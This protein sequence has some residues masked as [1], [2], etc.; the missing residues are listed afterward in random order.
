[1]LRATHMAQP[2]HVNTWIVAG[3]FFFPYLFKFHAVMTLLNI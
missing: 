1:M 2:G 3:H